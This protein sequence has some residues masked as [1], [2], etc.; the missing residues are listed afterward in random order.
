MDFLNKAYSQLVD[1]FRSMT[2]AARMTVVLLMAAIVVSSGYL[3]THQ[4]T[5]ATSDLMHGA[6]VNPSQLPAMEAAFAKA[7]LTNYEVRGSQIFVPRGQEASYYAALA[8]AKALPVNFG[9]AMKAALDNSSFVDSGMQTQQRIK[10]ALQE[11][12]SLIIG[13]MNGVERA[14]VLYD[15]ATKSGFNK[16]K[17]VTATASVKPVG[18]TTLD[19]EKVS[20]IRHAVAG[21]I[22]GMKPENVTVADLNGRTW[23]GNAE[24]GGAAEDNLYVSLKRTYEA[25]LKSKILGALCYIPNVSVEPTVTLD[26]KKKSMKREVV[27]DPKAS[28]NVH[29]IEQSNTRSQ[30]SSGPAGRPGLAAQQPNAPA[31][32]GSSRTGGSKEEEDQSKTETTSLTS[33]SETETETVGLTPRLAKVSVGIPLSYFKKI[34]AERNPTP[35]GETPKTPDQ[36]A[37]EQIRGEEAPKIQKHV[38]Q[39]LPP[40]EGVDDPTQLVTV[41]IFQDIMADASSSSDSAKAALSWLGENWSTLGSIA[42]VGMTIMML[43]SLVKS[44]PALPPPV[45]LPHLAS[46]EGM[47]GAGGGGGGE[48]GAAA[49]GDAAASRL[50]RFTT[51]P[52]LRDELSDIVKEDP[53]TAANVLKSWIGNVT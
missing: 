5:S 3:F 17:I 14:T 44:S 9:S 16:E 21:A 28:A 26:T 19:A 23:S 49:G 47:G 42:L 39:L 43:R 12:L 38:A 37:L 18:S 41:T 1:L 29:V 52:S 22:A 53:D 2:P 31:A 34:W 48:A 13:S 8:D 40:A 45:E 36:A 6:P 35:A 50:R 11:E 24:E 15:S 10:V 7:N 32:L 25:D 20:S 46:L 27:R 4:M 51:G 30:E 33:G